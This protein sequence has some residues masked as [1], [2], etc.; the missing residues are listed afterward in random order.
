M[1]AKLN[2]KIYFVAHLTIEKYGIM[3]KGTLTLLEK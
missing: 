3:F 1:Y 2:L